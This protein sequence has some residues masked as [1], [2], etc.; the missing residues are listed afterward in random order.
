MSLPPFGFREY[1]ARLPTTDLYL[2]NPLAEL[3]RQGARVPA[4]RHLS[5]NVYLVGRTGV[6]VRYGRAADIGRLRSSGARRIVYIVD[7]DFHAGAED[8]SLPGNTIG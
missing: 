2:L 8:A 5:D 7:D 1:L 3:R 6:I 4:T